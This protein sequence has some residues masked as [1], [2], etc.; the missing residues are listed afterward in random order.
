MI[1]F[2]PMIPCDLASPHV[3]CAYCNFNQNTDPKYSPP[4]GWGVLQMSP[5]GPGLCV[6][7]TCTPSF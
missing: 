7:P 1:E 3:T 6:C 2:D 4:S 5:K